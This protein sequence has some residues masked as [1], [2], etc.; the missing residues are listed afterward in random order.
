M[1]IEDLLYD[2][3]DKGLREEVMKEVG[4]IKSGV[5]KVKGERSLTLEMTYQLA[6]DRVIDR[7]KRFH[8]R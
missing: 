4:I 6:Y 5:N 8:L 7:W 3:H 2:A 1:S